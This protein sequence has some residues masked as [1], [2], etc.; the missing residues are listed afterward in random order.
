ML[1]TFE[2]QTQTCQQSQ[3]SSEKSKKVGKMQ[4]PIPRE[5]LSSPHSYLSLMV[6]VLFLSSWS[7]ADARGSTSKQSR[8][9]SILSATFLSV[10]DI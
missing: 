10:E 2:T 1:K 8:S 9:R 3:M 6:L 4:N 7:A 5:I